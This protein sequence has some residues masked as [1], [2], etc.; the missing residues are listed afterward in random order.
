[1]G[2][3]FVKILAK[4]EA[5]RQFFA[6]HGFSQ[7]GGVDAFSEVKMQLMADQLPRTNLDIVR[8]S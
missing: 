6:K 5:A 2:H 1:V 7:E 8:Q 3:F 4:N